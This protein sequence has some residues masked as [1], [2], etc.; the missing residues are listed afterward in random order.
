MH[1]KTIHTE[2]LRPS[3]TID[4]ISVCDHQGIQ[5]LMYLYN[6][7]GYSYRIFSDLLELL[8]F[9]EESKEPRWHFESEE[10]VNNF[11]KKEF[12]IG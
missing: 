8:A 6:Y 12:K 9:F 10:E 7:E 2:Y 5:Q 4:T 1:L 3:R 11:F